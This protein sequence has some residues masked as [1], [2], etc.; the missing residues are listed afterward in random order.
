MSHA[1]GMC[2]FDSDGLVMFFDYNGTTDVCV[3]HL[4]KTYDEVWDNIRNFNWL[5]CVDGKDEPCALFTDY[6]N[7]FYWKGRACRYCRAITEELSPFEPADDELKITHG[8]PKWAEESYPKE[9]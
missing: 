9:K 8:V 3:S 5:N 1:T 6:G 7:G 2:R 4:V